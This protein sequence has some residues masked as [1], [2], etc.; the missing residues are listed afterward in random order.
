[1]DS[2]TL[3]IPIEPVAKGRPRVNKKGW[4]FTPKKTQEFEKQ[5]A[6]YYKQTRAQYFDENTPLFVTMVFD[7]PI[8][9]SYSKKRRKWILDGYESYT[10]KP[11][12]DNLAK[13]VLDALNGVAWADDSQ[14]IGLNLR[15]QYSEE[16]QIWLSIRT[17]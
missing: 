14:I 9:K 3:I 7:M 6:D 12:L 2:V 16:P 15:K 13:G 17:V 11:D 10:K 4:T 1:M 5:V 8:P